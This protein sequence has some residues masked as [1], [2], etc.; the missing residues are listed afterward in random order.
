MH[1]AGEKKKKK[2]LEERKRNRSSQRCSVESEVV[3]KL[4]L[5][6]RGPLVSRPPRA[7]GPAS[8]INNV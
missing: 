1:E 3:G 5:V 8:H 2:R 4:V 7:G 6:E